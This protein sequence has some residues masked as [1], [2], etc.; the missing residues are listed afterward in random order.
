MKT[1]HTLVSGLLVILAVLLYFNTF[2][3]SFVYDEKALII[4][5]TFIRDT[6]NIPFFFSLEYWKNCHPGGK[7]YRPFRTVTFALDFALWGLNP[8]G[9]H[10]TNLLLY[11][12]NCV[13][14]YLLMLR[15]AKMMTPFKSA[16]PPAKPQDPLFRR[17]TPF[18]SAPPMD[19]P[20]RRM[21][22]LSE[23]V[24]IPFLT[25]LFFVGHPIHTEAVAYIKNRS[26]LITFLF[27]MAGFLL[28]FSFLRSGST[29]KRITVYTA[30]L[31]CFILGFITKEMAFSLPVMIGVAIVLFKPKN[32]WKHSLGFTIPFY[33]AAAVYLVIKKTV[34]GSVAMYDN[35]MPITL[36]Q[37]IMTVIM[38]IGR[39][40]K[41][42]LFPTGLSVDH[43]F[44]VPNSFMQTEVWLSCLGF[45]VLLGAVVVTTRRC[46][47]ISYGL[48]WTVVTLLPASNII[49]IAGRPF[50]EQRLYIPSLGFCLALACAFSCLSGVF[51]RL[52]P[53]KKG[54]TFA[55]YIALGVCLLYSYTTIKRNLDWKNPVTLW[56][57]AVRT[58]P[59]NPRAHNS[60]GLSY[61]EAG[62][63]DKAIGS[64][65]AAIELD[66]Y[67]I[68]A[69]YNCSVEYSSMGKRQD[70][71]ALYRQMIKHL[72]YCALGY[73]Y[74][75]FEFTA[76]KR[77]PEAISMFEKA[78]ELQPD[79][80]NAVVGLGYVYNLMGKIETAITW[81]RK[82]I[83]LEPDNLR[84]YHN[85]GLI[86]KN[87]GRKAESI[88][89]YKSL[90]RHVPYSPYGYFCLGLEY[91]SGNDFEQAASLLSKALDID[92]GFAE[93][94]FNL[95]QVYEGMGNQDRAMEMYRKTIVID[96]GFGRAHARLAM[97]Y[98]QSGAYD[99]A[100]EHNDRA[101]N[102]GTVNPGLID[103]PNQR[104]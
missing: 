70:S 62:Q 19:P 1:K 76:L 80:T 47:L 7:T 51:T 31:T 6:A 79:L 96:P 65:L 82:G 90:I 54:A 20:F 52:F 38:T 103:K 17:M 61:A 69:Y 21:N 48:T 60:L 78:I 73:S 34:L 67:F 63:T 74:M 36:W 2:G 27:Y 44:L 104:D 77:Y 101:R 97:H 11:A 98:Y 84:Q 3:N 86:Y 68:D 81:Y 92:P 75:G 45:V 89:L 28:Y 95:G 22:P 13:L 41:L 88:E 50:A 94:A 29:L 64:Y 87:L 39:Y 30:G 46:K 58:E 93:A 99:L 91:A 33:A 49:F 56:A 43:H 40:L 18:K 25:A 26:E 57:S 32:T 102:L 37:Q 4:N 42:L 59:G 10:L 24:T 55:I 15:L 14:V 5:N 53:G 23:T 100:R 16:P 12:A 8:W 85:L 71:I 72:P 66:P 35:S 83:E 9:Y